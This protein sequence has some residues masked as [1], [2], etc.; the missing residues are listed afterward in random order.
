MNAI[1]R[2]D[3]SAGLDMP[4]ARIRT[5]LQIAATKI[6]AIAAAWAMGRQCARAGEAACI[7]DALDDMADGET[8]AAVEAIEC[9]AVER[10]HSLTG[11]LT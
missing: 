8:A 9:A 7:A 6:R 5:E 11:D 4:P 10:M 1:A 2:L 3:R